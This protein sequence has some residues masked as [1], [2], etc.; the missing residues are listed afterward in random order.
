MSL[1]NR[2]CNNT[3]SDQKQHF[4]DFNIHKHLIKI[5]LY[6]HKHTFNWYKLKTIFTP[7]L[8][9]F[10]TN[11]FGVLGSGPI[12]KIHIN[13][14]IIISKDYTWRTNKINQDAERWEQNKKTFISS[15]HNKIVGL[16]WDSFVW[17]ESLVEPFDT[18]ALC[19]N[20]YFW[21]QLL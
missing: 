2:S 18:P 17:V 14:T 13:L 20:A 1:F 9:F 15:T 16:D 6:L 10:Q 8:W 7:F 11:K 21:I 4:T 3:C 19:P 5:L 12:A